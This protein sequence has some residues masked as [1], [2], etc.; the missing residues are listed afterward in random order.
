MCGCVGVA[1]DNS[2]AWECEAL[3][4]ADNVDDT[5]TLI[6]KAKIC[7]AELLHILLQRDA[8]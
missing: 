4:R 7:D 1:T 3:L 5:L 6:R 8:L 2:S